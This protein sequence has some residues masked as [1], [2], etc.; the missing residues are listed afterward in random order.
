MKIKN[1]LWT[2]AALALISVAAFAQVPVIGSQV[3][4][5]SGYQVN[6]AA[7][8]NDY[9]CGNGSFFIP[10]A[11]P[12]TAAATV[13]YQS[14]HNPPGTTLPSEPVLTFTSRFLLTDNPGLSTLV[15]LANSGV[16]PGTYTFPA[17]VTVDIY[18]HITAIA[19]GPTPVVVQS[20]SVS[21][22]ATAGTTDS[23]CTGTITLPVAMADNNY[24]PALTINAT[25]SSGAGPFL[26]LEV[27]GALT[28]TTIPYNI[29]CTF[30]CTVST[31]NT[32]YVIARHN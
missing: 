25:A 6:G 26:S 16:T 23:N 20:F 9:L 10:S 31:A 19:N 3:N 12:C 7:P 21:G 13:F 32:I 4:S 18:G 22:C 29:T 27:A 2:L 5:V 17:S 14:M 15:D 11:S 8:N 24:T 28:A 30:G 1:K